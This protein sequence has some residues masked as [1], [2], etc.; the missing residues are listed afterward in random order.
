MSDLPAVVVLGVVVGL[1]A[2][3]LALGLVLIY[4]ANRFINFA[5]VQMGSVASA[6]LAVL[7][8]RLDVPYWPALVVALAVGCA[9]GAGVELLL[10]WRLFDKSRLVLLVATI[11]IAQ[12]LLF[13]VVAGPLTVDPGVLAVEGF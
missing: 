5:Q 4:R 13:A 12:L 10:G 1:Q 3:L 9:V 11:G 8:L 7:V 2:S 6:V